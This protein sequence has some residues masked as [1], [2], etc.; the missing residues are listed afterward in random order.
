MLKAGTAFPAAGSR[1]FSGGNIVYTLHLPAKLREPLQHLAV[2]F[3]SLLGVTLSVAAATN[4]A[5]AL[6]VL[7]GVEDVAIVLDGSQEIP[8]LSGKMINVTSGTRGYDIT[9][10]AGLPVTIWHNGEASSTTSRRESISVLLDRMR[11]QPTPLEMVAVDLSDQALT[12]T[13]AEEI[14]YYDEI[15]ETDPFQTVRVASAD[16]PE[17]TE[18]VVQEG[19]EGVR[20][21]VYEVVWS[22]GELVSRQFVEE[23]H[24][25]A[26]DEIVEYGTAAAAV[27]SAAPIADV[28]KNPDGSGTLVLQSGD[29]L[30]FS[31]A[32]SMT[33]TAYTAGYGGADYTTATGTFVDIGT[34]AVDKS[35]IPLGTR[36]YIVTDDGIVYGMSVACDTGVRGNKVDLY[37]HTYDECI[38]FGRRSCTVY[39]LE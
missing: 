4:C 28:I 36:M 2:V 17:G 21:S 39:I 7:T 22:S 37:F 33:A 32:K 3:V 6:Y 25:T 23:I 5:S 27:G 30:N 8:D 13:I 18:Q 11:I 14:T 35:V 34:V 1:F 26:V 20:T 24:S 15:K 31:A 29:T 9:L 16:L 12:L 19:A 38:Q 10:K